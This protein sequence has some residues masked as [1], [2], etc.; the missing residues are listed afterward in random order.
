M[1][2]SQYPNLEPDQ[3]GQAISAFRAENCPYCDA[4]KDLLIKPFCDECLELLTPQLLE[5]IWNRNM[6]VH[7]FHPAMAHLSKVSKSPHGK[8]LEAESPNSP[9][10]VNGKP[11]G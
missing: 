7:T 6:F 5:D 11:K 3:I 4:K 10:S 9:A 2:P 1:N 8:N